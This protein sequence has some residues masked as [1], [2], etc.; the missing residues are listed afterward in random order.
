M[1]DVRIAAEDYGMTVEQ[2][3]ANCYPEELEEVDWSN[4]RPS[5]ENVSEQLRYLN[6]RIERL[7][8]ERRI[9]LKWGYPVPEI[10]ENEISEQS[11]NWTLLFWELNEWF[12]N[13]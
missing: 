5:A 1:G 6:D 8:Q 4:D 7:E 12:I 13:E 11:K 9:L 2:F 3:F 10:L